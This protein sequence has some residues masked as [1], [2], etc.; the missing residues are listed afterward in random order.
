MKPWQYHVRRSWTLFH[1]FYQNWTLNMAGVCKEWR[2]LTGCS[3]N[4]LMAV[5]PLG[6]SLSFIYH[7]TKCEQGVDIATVFCSSAHLLCA[8][9]RS[10]WGDVDTG[11]IPWNAAG[12]CKAVQLIHTDS[13]AGRDGS[14]WVLEILHPPLPLTCST[15]G[16]M[17]AKPCASVSH[18]QM[19]TAKHFCCVV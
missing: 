18:S 9:W 2:L 3:K 16:R 7:S 14:P 12:T 8:F 15:M 10:V 13:D 1:I 4:R 17:P 19:R 5:W 6:Q 11:D